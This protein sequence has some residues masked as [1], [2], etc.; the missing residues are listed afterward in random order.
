MTSR[1]NLLVH[2]ADGMS[3][4]DR[5]L[6]PLIEKFF[7]IVK[8]EPGVNYNKNDTVV[9]AKSQQIY[10]EKVARIGK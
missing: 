4:D 1:L 7:N 6:K 5:L 9:V 2:P 8:Y 3:F 10:N